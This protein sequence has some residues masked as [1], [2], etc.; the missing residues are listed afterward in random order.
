VKEHSDY[1]WLGTGKT[2]AVAPDTI[3]AYE[4]PDGLSDGLNF[5]FGDFHV[6]FYRMP[7]A[8]EMIEKSKAAPKVNGNL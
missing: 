4:K 1:V 5:L 3:I 2:A 8:M 7:E 6:E